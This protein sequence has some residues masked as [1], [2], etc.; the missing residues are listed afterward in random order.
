MICWCTHFRTPPI[1]V[2]EIAYTVYPILAGMMLVTSSHCWL[3]RWLVGFNTLLDCLSNLLTSLLDVLMRLQLPMFLFFSC[4]L[5]SI[6]MKLGPLR[7]FFMMGMDLKPDQ[8]FHVFFWMKIHVWNILIY[9]ILYHICGPK[10]QLFEWCFYS[11]EDSTDVRQE[12]GQRKMADY[13]SQARLPRMLGLVI[14]P[15]SWGSI[16]N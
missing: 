4:R 8:I 10:H 9:T 6:G 2:Y 16:L 15:N 3:L 7:L 14:L 13:V 5:E 11:S 12:K 1:C